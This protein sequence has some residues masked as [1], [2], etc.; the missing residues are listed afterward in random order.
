MISGEEIRQARI[1]LGESQT[2]FGRRLGVDQS[3][4]HRWE[5]AGP[6]EGGAAPKLLEQFLQQAQIGAVE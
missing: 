1:K 6:P 2:A 5:T 3:T 4:I